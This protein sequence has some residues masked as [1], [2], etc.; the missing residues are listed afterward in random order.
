M[1]DINKEEMREKLGNIDQIRDII[2][3]PQLREY[4]SRLDN[5]ESNIS[6]LEKDLR[7]RLEQTQNTCLA[8]LRSA[9]ESLDTKVKSL[10][11]TTQNDNAEIRQL[12]D[13]FNK[14]YSSRID[15]LSQTVEQ[16][17]TS[18]QKELSETREK[19]QENNRTLKQEIFAQLEKRFSNLKGTKVSRDDLAEILF[20]L[21]LR[22]KGN[23]LAPELQKAASNETKNDVFLIEASEV[24]N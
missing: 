5:I 7:E 18:I 6:L 4:N 20:E 21:G 13:H 14:K 3:G 17:T 19:L 22:I 24:S 12:I 9:V 8:E 16:Q 11:L 1:A 23:E 2:F 10:G 15:A